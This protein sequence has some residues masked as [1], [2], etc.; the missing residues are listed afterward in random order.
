MKFMKMAL[1]CSCIFAVCIVSITADRSFAEKKAK[2]PSLE[3]GV[4]IGHLHT[5]DKV[6]TISKGQKGIAYTIK[7]K[8]GKTLDANLSEKKFQAKYPALFDQIKDGRAGNDATLRPMTI[9]IVHPDL[10][11]IP[12][13]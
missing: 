5:R 13:K 7:T 4:V 1:L 3:Q 12:D 10:R 8:A 11:N 6:V 2:Q 9:P